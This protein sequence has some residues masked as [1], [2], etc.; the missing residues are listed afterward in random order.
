VIETGIAAVTVTVT[1]TGMTTATGT[2]AGTGTGA[3]TTTTTGTGTTT[4]TGT[5]VSTPDSDTIGI[6]TGAVASRRRSAGL[7][8][9][10]NGATRWRGSRELDLR[11]ADEPAMSSM[12]TRA[13]VHQRG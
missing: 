1:G 7:N 9:P 2:T 12:T 10:G 5:T 8:A 13:A 6:E 3:A 11:P 4:T